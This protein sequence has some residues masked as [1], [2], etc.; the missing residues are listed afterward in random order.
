MYDAVYYGKPIVYFCPDYEEFKGGLN[1]YCDTVVPIENGFG[2]LYKTAEEL[3]D[4]L[5]NFDFDIFSKNY[6]KKYDVFIN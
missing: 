1:L 6:S 2:P 3:L 5:F 4:A